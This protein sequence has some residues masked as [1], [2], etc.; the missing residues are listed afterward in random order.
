MFGCLPLDGPRREG[1]LFHTYNTQGT[2]EK[3]AALHHAD[4][5]KPV[6]ASAASVVM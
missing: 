5:P 4:F 1:G 2:A 6:P 3:R